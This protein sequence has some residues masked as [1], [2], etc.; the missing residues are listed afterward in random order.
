MKY[1]FDTFS[2][3]IDMLNPM[4]TTFNLTFIVNKTMSSVADHFVRAPNEAH[5]QNDRHNKSKAIRWVNYIM[6]C[7]E[8]SIS[9]NF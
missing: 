1:N 7:G 3:S 6:G 4:K 9:H 2:N 8:V 5:L